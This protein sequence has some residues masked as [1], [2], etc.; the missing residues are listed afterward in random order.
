M[1]QHI[2]LVFLQLILSHFFLYHKRNEQYRIHQMAVVAWLQDNATKFVH[3]SARTTPLGIVPSSGVKV[4]SGSNPYVCVSGSAAEFTLVNTG[5]ANLTTANMRYKIGTAAWVPFVWN[6]D[7]APG[8]SEVVQIPG[9]TL[10]TNGAVKIEVRADNSNLGIQTDLLR[11]AILDLRALFVAPAPLPWQQTFQSGSFPSS[12]NWSTFLSGTRGW[13][14]ASNAG[15]GGSTRS[16]KNEMYYYANA[17]TS[18]TSQKIDLSTASGT[19]ALTFDYAYAKYD[20][21]YYDSLSVAVS[22]D[23]GETWSEIFRDGYDGL[24]TGASTTAEYVPAAGDWVGKTFDISSFNGQPE[25]LIKFDAISGYGNNVYL[26]NINVA[27]VSSVKPLDLVS[28]AVQ[29]NPTK[30]VSEV[31]FELPSAQNIQ[32]RVFDMLGSLVQ[33]QDLGTLTTGEHRIKM[34][35]TRLNSGSYRIVIQGAEGVA[36]TQWMVVK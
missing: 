21:Q 25:V 15:S 32:I 5:T 19:T 33:N 36:Q 23:C 16:V 1:L 24:A 13:K 27:T 8:A 18:M 9:V 22:T 28:F 4:T 26:D 12:G 35:A 31:R 30:D 14:L 11:S 7:L 10:T 17:T 34:D 6:G 20:N 29:P 2:G 3:N